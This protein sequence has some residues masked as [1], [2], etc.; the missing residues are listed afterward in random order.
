MAF[1]DIFE[2]LFD[3]GPTPGVNEAEQVIQ[4]DPVKDS[5]PENWNTA[6][7]GETWSTK[8]E[9]WNNEDNQKLWSV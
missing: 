7:P 4:S 1:D 5:A 6:E 9:V 3:I 8:S 2:D